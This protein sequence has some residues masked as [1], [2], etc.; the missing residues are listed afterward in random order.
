MLLL[1]QHRALP[2]RSSPSRCAAASSMALTSAVA[3]A[4]ACWASW[5]AAP[6]CSACGRAQKAS[7][8]SHPLHSKGQDV[9][10]TLKDPEF[11]CLPH[12][13]RRHGL[14]TVITAAIAVDT[15]TTRTIHPVPHSY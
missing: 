9:P 2:A 1:F 6:A 13:T 11:C 5:R 4:A 10:A 15:R 8:F 14:G 7:H 3:A 12:S